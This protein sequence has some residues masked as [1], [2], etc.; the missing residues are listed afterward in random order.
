MIQDTTKNPAPQPSRPGRVDLNNNKVENEPRQNQRVQAGNTQTSVGGA[1]AKAGM[2]IA[3]KVAICTLLTG[4]CIAG[5][6][7]LT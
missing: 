3:T 1:A 5:G 2:S 4:S 6:I 7:A